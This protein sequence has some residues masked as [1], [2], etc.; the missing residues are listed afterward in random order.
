MTQIASSGEY[1]RRVSGLELMMK[2]KEFDG[3][4]PKQL[5]NAFIREHTKLHRA[6]HLGNDSGENSKF[7]LFFVWHM[8]WSFT[9]HSSPS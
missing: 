8:L 4:T 2:Y 1:D 6:R 3:Y 5:K 7:E 9:H